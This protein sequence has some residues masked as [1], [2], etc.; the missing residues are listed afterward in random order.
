MVHVLHVIL[1][2]HIVYDI[3]KWI[4]VLITLI[5]CWFFIYFRCWSNGLSI[6]LR[7]E[8]FD[9]LIFWFFRSPEQRNRPKCN[10][11]SPCCCKPY[12]LPLHLTNP[13]LPPANIQLMGMVIISI[14]SWVQWPWNTPIFS[15]SDEQ[16]W[17]FY[18]QIETEIYDACPLNDHR[19]NPHNKNIHTKA[20]NETL[21]QMNKNN[22]LPMKNTFNKI[23]QMKQTLDN[24]RN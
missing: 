15:G 20:I 2:T 3:V 16:W 10:Y 18:I 21:L 24:R 22:S 14:H 23:D 6:P 8:C 9:F 4:Y 17:E 7:R 11:Y 1:G 19:N 13:Q 12:T 5:N